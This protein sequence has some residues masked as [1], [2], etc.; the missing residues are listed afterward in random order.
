MRDFSIFLT[1]G[2]VKKQQ[3]DRNLSESLV[4]DCLERFEDARLSIKTGRK[5]KFI[6]E[7]IYEALRTYLS[8]PVDLHVIIPHAK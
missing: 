1:D 7:N 6:Y 3:P 4:K 8:S 2:N 5:P